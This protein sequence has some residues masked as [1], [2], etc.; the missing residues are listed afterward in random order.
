MNRLDLLSAK[1]VEA[2][3]TGIHNA[4]AARLIAGWIG[5]ND[6]PNTVYHVNGWAKIL[7]PSIFGALRCVA[8]RC[9]VHAHD[10]F[11]ACPNGAFFDYQAQ[12]LCPHR[13]LSARC[14]T[15]ACDRRSYAHKLWRVARGFNVFSNLRDQPEFSR[16]ILLHDTMKA[17]FVHAGYGA[18]RFTT[19][20]N[21][22]GL[23][24]TQR[25]EVENNE[26]F[27]FIGRL[28]AEKGIE[29]VIAVAGKAG[30]PLCIIGD[31]PLMASAKAAGP[32][33][34][35][36]GWLSHAEIALHIRNARGLIMPSRYP[37]PFG[38]VAI[39]AARNGV[40]VILSADAFLAPE[41]VSAG[42]AFACNTRD[43]AAFTAT[44]AKLK[45]MSKPEIRQMSERAVVAS[46]DLAM[47]HFDWRDALLAEYR[48][49]LSAAH[50]S[51]LTRRNPIHGVVA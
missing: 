7:S 23:E 29:D 28:D 40:P 42:A 35:A 10:F 26:E 15:T 45:Y 34:R 3:A 44:I 8:A 33:V 20:R 39:E 21:P 36:L 2:F 38:L 25:V 50:V 4:Q 6:T 11:A 31:G 12:A 14:I 16:I 5:A 22:A 49:L 47:S 13:P 17:F 27:F 24:A 32:H 37:E 19:I 1:P 9:I 18:E 46:Q 43:E 48:S 30:V 51:R 41:L